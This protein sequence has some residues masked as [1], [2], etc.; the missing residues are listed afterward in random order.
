VDIDLADNRGVVHPIFGVANTAD[1]EQSFNVVQRDWYLCAVSK[2]VERNEEAPVVDILPLNL[3]W[4][5][6]ILGDFTT[7]F[8]FVLKE[9]EQRFVSE[10]LEL[11]GEARY[12]FF[13][14]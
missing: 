6:K 13:A 3:R 2:V 5:C 7:I 11:P 1:V 8:L 12:Q 9:Y 4:V 10:P 14:A